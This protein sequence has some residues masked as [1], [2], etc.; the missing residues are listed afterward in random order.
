MCLKEPLYKKVPC[1]PLTGF[2]SLWASVCLCLSFPLLV[3]P[4]HVT[5]SR[6]EVCPGK[7]YV[8]KSNLSS[9][10]NYSEPSRMFLCLHQLPF[11]FCS[12][13][14][15]LQPLP[16]GEIRAPWRFQPTFPHTEFQEALAGFLTGAMWWWDQGCILIED[17]ALE[18]LIGKM[19]QLWTAVIYNS[20]IILLAINI[21][22]KLIS[23]GAP[24][25]CG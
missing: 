12:N 10:W 24:R 20:T 25:C 11:S 8:L 17:T 7:S 13:P 6:N 15:T 21:L 14:T 5:D 1:F 18:G 22:Y 3:L 23:W 16:W 9:L 4:V 19:Q 2:C